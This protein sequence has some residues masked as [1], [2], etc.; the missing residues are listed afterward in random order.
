MWFWVFFGFLVGSLLFCAHYCLLVIFQFGMFWLVFWECMV[1]R[2]K[3]RIGG[4]RAFSSLLSLHFW[5]GGCFFFRFLLL[6]AVGFGFFFWVEFGWVVLIVVCMILVVFLFLSFTCSM[7]LDDVVSQRVVFGVLF[8]YCLF[9]FFFFL[10]DFFFLFFYYFV[11]KRVCAC[12][13]YFFFFLFLTTVFFRVIGCCLYFGIVLF[14]RVFG[15]RF[16]FCFK[17]HSGHLL[18]FFFVGGSR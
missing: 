2:G 15:C 11:W 8:G 9:C 13:T 1:C 7:W 6:H 5:L 10:C 16:L 17:R 3:V 12:V 4:F 14:F 18:L